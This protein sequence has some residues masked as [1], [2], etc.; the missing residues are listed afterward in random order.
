MEAQ[1]AL[2]AKKSRGGLLKN[3]WSR[4]L[5]VFIGSSI[6]VSLE[7]EN[8]IVP[9]LLV[10]AILYP[11]FAFVMAVI[12]ILR[13]NF[14]PSPLQLWKGFRRQWEIIERGPIVMRV[15]RKKPSST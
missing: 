1:Q 3:R 13:F 10:Y 4:W 7:T 9:F 15:H 6:L 8:P 14:F 2:S 12:K 11:S 5:I